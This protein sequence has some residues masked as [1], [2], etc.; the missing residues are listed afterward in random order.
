[1]PLPNVNGN[2]FRIK[3]VINEQTINVNRWSIRFIGLRDII[4]AAANSPLPNVR[5]RYE[6]VRGILGPDVETT[7]EIALASSNFPTIGLETAQISRFND[8]FR[9][10]T[11]FT[12]IDELS[13]DF[14]DYVNGS[15]SAIMMLWQAMVG[16]KESGAI[17]FKQD[18]V[19]KNAEFYVYGPDAPAYDINGTNDILNPNTPPVE[20]LPYLQKYKLVNLY[21][22]KISMPSHSDSGEPRKITVNFNVDN[23]YPIEIYY[24]DYVNHTYINANQG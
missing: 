8:Q 1:M 7:L 23:V 12:L 4:N 24:Y 17:G 10:V 16:D 5:K 19:L 15:A 2:I 21:P 9:T 18:Y 3:H 20:K 13:I 6:M 11:K 22:L 14:W